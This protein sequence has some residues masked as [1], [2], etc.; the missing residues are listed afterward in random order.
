MFDS[1]FG[2][3]KIDFKMFGHLFLE[4]NDFEYYG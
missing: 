4:K 3:T 1:T 2:C